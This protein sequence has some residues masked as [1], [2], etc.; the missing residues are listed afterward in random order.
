MLLDSDL[1]QT[2]QPVIGILT[3]PF[4]DEQPNFPYE[5]FVWEHNTN[6]VHYAGSHAVPIKYDLADEDLYALLDQING[7]FF[8]GGGVDMIQPD[9]TQH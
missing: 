7:V 9:G 5:Q 4:W 8:T 1:W 3:M 6:F 2:E